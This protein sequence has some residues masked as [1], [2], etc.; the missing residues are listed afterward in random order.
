MYIISILYILN[1]NKMKKT[2]L[3]LGAL[4]IS[5]T[6]FLGNLTFSTLA[7]ADP[8]SLEGSPTLAMADPGSLE[9]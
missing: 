8:G 4:T 6:A 1:T 3:L 7:M 5:L 2:L 9:G